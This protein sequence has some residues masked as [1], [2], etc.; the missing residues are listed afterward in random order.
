MSRVSTADCYLIAFDNTTVLKEDVY[1]LNLTCYI[2]KLECNALIIGQ[3]I[4]IPV[5]YDS[6]LD[7]CIKTKK[8]CAIF[9]DLEEKKS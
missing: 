9:Y 8:K 2:M 1:F 4:L 6:L 3:C 7:I 5:F